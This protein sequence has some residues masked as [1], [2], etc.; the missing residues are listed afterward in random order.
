MAL[1]KSVPTA[2]GVTATYHRISAISLHFDESVVDVALAGYVDQACRQQ[3][4]QPVS[5]MPGIRLPLACL[6]DGQ[7]LRQSIYEQLKNDPA[8]SEATDC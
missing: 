3:H 8:W 5:T 6:I 1:M 7:S 4:F 2:F